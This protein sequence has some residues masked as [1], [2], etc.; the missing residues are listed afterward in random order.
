LLYGSIF[1]DNREVI[2]NPD[3]ILPQQKVKMPKS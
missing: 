2:R 1:Q 3:L